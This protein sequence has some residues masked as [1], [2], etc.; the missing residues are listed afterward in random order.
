MDL[1]STRT[2]EKPKPPGFFRLLVRNTG[3]NKQGIAV[4]MLASSCLFLS[5][6]TLDS[7]RR[8]E[9]LREQYQS[10]KSENEQLRSTLKSLSNIVYE[11]EATG[12]AAVPPSETKNFMV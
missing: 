3:K 7:K 8:L 2:M 11:D 1:S 6:S 10:V 12:L 9:E 5:I 4:V